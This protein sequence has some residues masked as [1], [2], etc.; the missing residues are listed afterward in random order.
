[1]GTVMRLRHNAAHR[2]R[3]VVP[4]RTDNRIL[5]H[6]QQRA[7]AAGHLSLAH[8]VGIAQT[9]SERLPKAH[10]DEVTVGIAQPQQVAVAD[11]HTVQDAVPD[12]DEEPFTACIRHSLQESVA[13]RL[14]QPHSQ[15]VADSLAH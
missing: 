10:P 15:Q 5:G 6:P 9:D 7:A 4:V 13:D 14:A 3:T 2:N 1:M 11:C 12:P 8:G